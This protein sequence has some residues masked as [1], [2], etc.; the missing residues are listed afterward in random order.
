MT[1]NMTVLSDRLAAAVNLM[2]PSGCVADIGCDH[3]HVAIY[4]IENGFAE[5]VIACDINKGP[6]SRA[7]QN[8]EKAGLSDRIECRL[9]DG[10]GGIEPGECDTIIIAGMGGPLMM[11][12][13]SE[14][15]AVSD[16]ADRLILQPQSDVPGFRSFIQKN[17]MAIDDETMV[18]DQGKYY[19][20][21]RVVHGV[22][23][24]WVGADNEYGKML[25]E[26]KDPILRD[27]LEREY[28]YISNLLKTLDESD[29]SLRAKMSF[30]KMRDKLRM[31]R[32][33]VLRMTN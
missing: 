23:K 26:K 15:S 3:A 7:A 9:C 33:T 13:L 32:E 17:K 8:I 28:E 5:K 30:E 6:L 14:G 29:G 31:N 16:K 12:I 11:K 1:N 4:L 21:M 10:L 20:M 22:Q 18:F 19:P 2:T 27:F 25:I 24:E